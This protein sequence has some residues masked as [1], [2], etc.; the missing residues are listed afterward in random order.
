MLIAY[1]GLG[2]GFVAALF[3]TIMP[4]KLWEIFQSWKAEEEPPY[5]YFMIMRIVGFLVML[6][7]L[8]A[9]IT[10]AKSTQNNYP[11]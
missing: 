10:L 3:L 2:A 7:L 1:I 8:F 4:R 6:F 5:S 9:L 11:V